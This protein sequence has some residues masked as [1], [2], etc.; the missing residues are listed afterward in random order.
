MSA[1]EPLR[2]LLGPAI[3][4]YLALKMALGRRFS[5]ERSVLAHLDHFLAKRASGASFTAESFAAWC[6]TF[7]HL[8]PTVRRNW[9]RIAR[10]LSLYVRR[11]DPLCFVPDPAGFPARSA[12]QRPHIFT[13][14]EIRQLL[15]AASAVHVR[16]NSPLAPAVFRLALVLLYTAG[17]RRGELVR[18]LLSDYDPAQRTLRI[19]ASKFHKT[20]LVALSVDAT[21]E[22]ESYLQARRGLTRSSTAEDA[23]LLVTGRDGRRAYSGMSLGNRLRSVF[24]RTTIRTERGRVPRVHDL[25]HTYAVHALLRWYHTGLD[26]QAKLPALAMA[27]GHVSIAS[28]AYYLG[29]LTPVAEAASER[30]AR[31]AANALAALAPERGAR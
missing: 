4:A 11:S 25:R 3:T 1:T 20:R 10:N 16:G 14:Q 24:G 9:M 2:S 23:P 12:P 22:I 31:H 17:L 29:F 26:V 13:E 18:L 5:V 15:R 6:F 27:M 21:R 28:T 30:F 8:S 19:R 7:A